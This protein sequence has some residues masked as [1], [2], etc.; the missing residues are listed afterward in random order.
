M[1]RSADSASVS[2]R[3]DIVMTVRPSPCSRRSRL[4]S[5]SCAALSRLAAASSSTRTGVLIDRTAATAVRCRCPPDSW[6]TMLPRFADK[7][8]S[9]RAA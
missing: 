3:A 9:V 1:S 5:R 2:M 6:C 8:T 4:H 7:P